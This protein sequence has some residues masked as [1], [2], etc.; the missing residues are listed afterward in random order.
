MNAINFYQYD[1]IFDSEISDDEIPV[2]ANTMKFHTTKFLATKFPLPKNPQE[3][4][5]CLPG[6]STGKENLRLQLGQLENTFQDSTS[7]L[8]AIRRNWSMNSVNFIQ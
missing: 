2:F 7:F 1:E 4:Y 3:K 5:S 6:L 8:I